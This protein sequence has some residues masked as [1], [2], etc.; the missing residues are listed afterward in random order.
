MLHARSPAEID[1]ARRRVV[2]IGKLSDNIIGF[3]RF[4]IGLDGMLAWIPGFGEAY[5]LM[6]GALLV[7][8]GLRVR[9]PALVLARI[10]LI[11]GLRSA[12]GAPAAL[13]LGPLYPISGALVDVF[14]GHKW[15]ADMLAKSIDNTLYI[16]GK[17]RDLAADPELANAVDQAR[18][19]RRRVVFLG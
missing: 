6:A 2:R 14:R 1:V 12:A 3:G 8:L 10:L 7:L 4:G 19:G 5:S 15:S 16:E 13:L 17:K 11:I 18:A 9:A